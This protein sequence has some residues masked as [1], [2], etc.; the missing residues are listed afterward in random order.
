MTVELS[1]LSKAPHK[2]LWLHI[3]HAEADDSVGPFLRD[4]EKI[5]WTVQVNSIG[6]EPGTVAKDIGREGTGPF[7]EWTESE[8]LLFMRQCRRVLKSYGLVG[9]P[10]HR[11]R[12]EDML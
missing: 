11:L 7:N 1:F 2:T 3:E 5:G 6:V 4:L 12:L 9:V 8:M 10:H